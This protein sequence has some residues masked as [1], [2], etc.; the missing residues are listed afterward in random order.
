MAKQPR[1]AVNNNLVIET[2]TLGVNHLGGS[3]S[4]N[5]SNQDKILSPMSGVSRHSKGSHSAQRGRRD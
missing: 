3:S 5:V 2:K 4:H 1:Q